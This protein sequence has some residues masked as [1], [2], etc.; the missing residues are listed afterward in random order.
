MIRLNLGAGPQPIDGWQNLDAKTGH[1]IYPLP[2][3]DGTVDVVR[4]SHVL[5][6]YPRADVPK[7]LADW[8]RVLKPG[9][10]LRLA[11]PDFGKVAA[12][13][14]AGEPMNVQGYVMGGQ[15]DEYDFH[16]TAFDTPTLPR[17]MAAAGLMLI[18]PW[19]SEIQDCAAL[20]VSLNL[21]GTKPHHPQLTVA[22]VMSLPRLSWTANV[23]CWVE[24][25]MPH[26]IAPRCYTG[27]YWDQCIERSIEE[28]IAEQK[29][30]LI[31]TVDYDTVFTRRDVGMMIQLAC[32][33]PEADAIAPIQSARGRKGPLMA[34]HGDKVREGDTDM[35]HVPSFEFAGNLKR[36]ATA[37]FGMTLLRTSA[38]AKLSKPWFRSTPAPDG[39]WGDGRR[40]ADIAFWDAWEAAGNSM[41]I[42]NRVP[43]GHLEMMIS[44][45]GQD[46]Q[47]IHQDY[48]EWR[49][50]GVPTEIWR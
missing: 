33:H 17:A 39:T 10:E 35:V 13:Y 21:A 18:R 50:S 20:P 42:A 12:S 14:V 46:L 47:K 27:A 19:Q 38:I 25:L 7:V 11:V 24:A 49:K 34:V 22:C 9:G 40:D 48:N 23:M 3:G 1:S 16:R 32:C 29:P 28:A 15:G 37:H 4:A 8:I 45:P 2:F 31:L 6:H 5:E 44:W 26:Q 41:F 30:D 43:V 36:A